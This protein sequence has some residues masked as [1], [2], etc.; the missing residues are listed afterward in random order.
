MGK[1]CLRLKIVP[2]VQL[3]IPSDPSRFSEAIGFGGPGQAFASSFA[4]LDGGGAK[5]S[6]ASLG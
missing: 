3:T 4:A 6:G 2:E 5:S 1:A